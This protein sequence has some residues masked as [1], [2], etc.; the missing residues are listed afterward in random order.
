M[1]FKLFTAAAAAGL[2]LAAGVARAEDA[3]AAPA[4]AATPDFT[5]T[6]SAALV[7]Q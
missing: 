2:A 1:T 3:P 4:A 6:G 7:S 5:V